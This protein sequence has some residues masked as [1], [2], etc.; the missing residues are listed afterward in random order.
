M[1]WMNEYLKGL[2]EYAR[3][4]VL[5]NTGLKVLAL[6]IT[7]VLWLSIASRPVSQVALNGAIEFNLPESPPLTVSKYDTLT[8]RVFLEGPRDA[9]DTLRAGQL[10][11]TADM[12]AVE[13]GF[14]VI[15]LKV[16]PVRNG[17]PANVKV[18]EIEPPTIRVTVERMIETEVTIT[19]RWEGEPPPGSE[20]IDWQIVPPTVKVAGAESQ[21]RDI[22]GVSTETVR[23]TD[24]TGAFSE[25][26]AID[27]GASNL[28]LT[29]DSPRKVMLT[30]NIAEV[31]KERVIEDVPIAVF[32]APARARAIPRFVK[33]TVFGARSILAGMT[34]ADVNVG[35][36]YQ[37]GSRLFTPRV[38]LS[39]AFAD[40][41][42]VR[43]VEP[44]AIQ[45]R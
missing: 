44:Q 43:S 33:V 17:L 27:I 28:N 35:V 39:P 14:R 13:P 16:D 3:D 34:V 6:L 5:E 36:E 37:G 10:T 22:N 23:L 29:S 8:A 40:R 12:S 26:V 7:G 20:V 21:M 19:P 32:G 9:L 45:V 38:T 18:S 41:V 1:D 15:P 11:V 31:R 25:Q 2:K 4:Y 42:V 24:K 30:V